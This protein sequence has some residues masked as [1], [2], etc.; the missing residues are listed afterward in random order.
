MKNILI[1]DDNEQS[2]K[3]VKYALKENDYSFIEA[4]DGENALEILLNDKPDLL[5]LDWMMPQLSGRSMI[6]LLDEI[7]GQIEKK[8]KM[9]NGKFDVII[10][11][12]VKM[13]DLNLPNSRYFR[14]LCYIS[15]E[16][17]M[18]RQIE[19]IKK[20]SKTKLEAA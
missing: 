16:W 7:L 1:V 8:G 13:P 2:R 15:K 18:F 10:Y 5:I 20:I 19:R 17:S 11:S 14:Y 4:Q 9:Q 12:S 3:V 6:I